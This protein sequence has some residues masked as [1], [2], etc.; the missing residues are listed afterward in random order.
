MNAYHASGGR[1]ENKTKKTP[2]LNPWTALEVLTVKCCLS[3]PG[4]Y[5]KWCGKTDIAEIT[6][7]LLCQMMNV[8]VSVEN[9]LANVDFANKKKQTRSCLVVSA[10]SSWQLEDCLSKEMSNH[11]FNFWYIFVEKSVIYSLHFWQRRENGW[12][13]TLFGRVIQSDCM[14]VVCN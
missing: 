13:K 14:K 12:F 2:K 7:C 4:T 11:D 1:K 8:H 3:L 5:V 9:F 10:Q 6:Y